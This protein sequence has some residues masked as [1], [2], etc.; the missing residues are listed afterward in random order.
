M[1][2]AISAVAAFLAMVFV[3]TP[4]SYAQ[5][6]QGGSGE[7]N[8]HRG[9]MRHELAAACSGKSEND[10]CTLTMNGKTIEG[11]CRGGRGGQNQGQGE[12]VC[13]PAHPMGQGRM[14]GGGGGGNGM[15]PRGG[16]MGGG[17][18]GGPGG[19]DSGGPNY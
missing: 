13:R 11:V 2:T 1:K 6:G 8:P 10:P 9:Q 14:G 18:G 12:L 5:M 15:G 19:G 4:M 7:N 16:G 17:Y 3:S